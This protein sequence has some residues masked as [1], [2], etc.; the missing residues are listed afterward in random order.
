M[1]VIGLFVVAAIGVFIATGIGV[2]AASSTHARAE[3]ARD[4]RVS[5][6]QARDLPAERVVD[7]SAMFE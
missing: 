1:R 6:L 3:L 4:A 5:P 7:L 2:W